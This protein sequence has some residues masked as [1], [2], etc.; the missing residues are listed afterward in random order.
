MTSNA[1]RTRAYQQGGER[2]QIILRHL[3]QIKY[4][5]QRVAVGLPP[6]VELEDLISAGVIGLL[7][8]LEKFDESKGVQFKTYAEV[9]IHGAILDSLREQDWAPRSLRR[10]VKEVAKAYGKVE[11]QLGRAASDE[12]IAQELGLEIGKFHVLL[13]QLK[14]LNIGHFQFAGQDNRGLD[15]DDVVLQSIPSR[16]EITPF[17]FC[18]RQELRSI[19]AELIE[20]LPE[21]ERL[22]ITLYHYEEL[23]MREVGEILGVNESRICQLH[24]RAILRLRGRLQKRLK[25]K[26]RK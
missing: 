23:T 20:L 12:E 9:R 25:R 21:R 11:Q 3:P 18:M 4:I 15:T 1:L 17:Q 24:T 2:E 6:H 14:G 7:D 19:L 8:A 10:K 16:E 13:D 26:V 5:A 22:V